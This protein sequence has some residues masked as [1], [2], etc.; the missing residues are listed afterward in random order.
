[1]KSNILFL[2]TLFSLLITQTSC[3]SVKLGEDFQPNTKKNITFAEPTT[4][5]TKIDLP[6]A[7]Q[8]WQSSVTGNSISYFADCKQNASN[9]KSLRTSIFGGIEDLKI[10]E[11]HFSTYNGR[12]ALHSIVTGKMEGVPVKINF[13]IFKKNACAYSVSYISVQD[14]YEKEV[15]YFKKF[16][17]GFKVN[18]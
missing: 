2:P 7:D 12:E 13:L 5:F 9:L 15:S 8:A 18:D 6:Q 4:P 1:M 14:K 11:E 10:S 3:V 17:E 16:L